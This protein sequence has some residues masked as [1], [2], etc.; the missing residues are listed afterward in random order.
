MNDVKLNLNGEVKGHFKS[1]IFKGH[2]RHRRFEPKSHA[3]TYPIFMLYLDLD[4]LPKLFSEKWYCSFSG[5]NFVRFKRRDF[6]SPEEPNLKKAVIDKV[7]GSVSIELAQS[8]CSVRVLA[9]L[10][11]LNILFNPVV[12]YY[13][14]DADQNLIAIVAEITNTPWE[15]KH[16]YVLPI[17]DDA[18]TSANSLPGYSLK[19]KEKHQFEFQKIFH[20]SPFNPM[21][22]DYRWVFSQP[23]EKLFVHMDNFIQNTSNEGTEENA[24][25]HFDATL[26]M[27][28]Y[29]IE[30]NLGK[31]LIQYPFMT[32]KV[33][34]GIYWQALKLKLKGVP[35]YDHPDT[36][37]P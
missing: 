3:F 17:G 1:A 21:N 31:T 35:F 18:V 30:Q 6:M 26:V 9:H 34:T 37:K 33:I 8:I 24:S 5:F 4:E 12:F 15:E 2:I 11:Y 7:A 13:C 28:R 36:S 27:S 22:M 29:D 25:K 23:G 20:V 19:G 14:Y 10:R 32:V 16:A